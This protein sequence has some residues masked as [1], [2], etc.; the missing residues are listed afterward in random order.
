MDFARQHWLAVLER[1][2]AFEDAQEGYVVQ[3]MAMF[4]L[5]LKR[6]SPS[7]DGDLLGRRFKFD[8]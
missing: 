1:D 5:N 8:E 2:S 7:G 4:S 3:P 6:F